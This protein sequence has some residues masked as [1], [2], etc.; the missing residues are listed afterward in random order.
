MTE[1]ELLDRFKVGLHVYDGNLTHKKGFYEPVFR[2]VFISNLLTEEERSK[3]ILHEIGH[4]NH[5]PNHY[6][7][8]L[9]KYEN[10]A[11]RFMISELLADYLKCYGIEDF[12]W[13]SFA[14]QYHIST[15]WGEAM[16][17]GEFRKIVS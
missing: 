12:N 6:E 13:V 8:L 5:N 11:D 2:V 7:R 17:L 3:V 10:E 1:K 4:M 14:K 16:I 9:L 15:T